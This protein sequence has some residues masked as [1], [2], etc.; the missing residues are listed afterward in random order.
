[1]PTPVI[2][3]RFFFQVQL[4][5]GDELEFLPLLLFLW[6]WPA[7]SLTAP[8]LSPCTLAFLSASA[9]APGVSLDFFDGLGGGACITLELEKKKS[10]LV[11]CLQFRRMDGE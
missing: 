2:A 4:D 5:L 6:A 7:T 9:A 3:L 8:F 1:M 10:F 11:F